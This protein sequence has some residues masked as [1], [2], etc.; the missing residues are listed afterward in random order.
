MEKILDLIENRWSPRGFSEKPVGTGKLKRIFRAA[1]LS[2]SSNNEQ[3]WRFIVGVKGQGE[4]WNKLFN[5][6]DEWNRQ[7][8]LYAPV[9]IINTGKL[10]FAKSN[11]KPNRHTLYDC[12][13]A[14]AYLSIQA[15]QEGL[16]VHQMGGFSRTKARE[17]FSIPE[18]FEPVTVIALGYKGSVEHLPEDIRRDEWH[19]KE[20]KGLDE[21]VFSKWGNPLF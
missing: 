11:D 16:Y 1:Q 14:A 20:R 15:M 13:Q 18:S 9:L 4:T 6:L 3:P 21:I 8:A 5:I 17:V 19:K 2:P 7:W 12:G 10:F